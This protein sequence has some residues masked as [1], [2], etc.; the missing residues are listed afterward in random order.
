MLVSRPMAPMVKMRLVPPLLMKGSG[1][2]VLGRRLVTTMILSM[3]GQKMVQ[4]SPSARMRPNVVRKN[5]IK[6]YRTQTEGVRHLFYTYKV[7]LS[8]SR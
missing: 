8:L 7:H 1:R 5:R 3:A 6:S 2:P 4:E